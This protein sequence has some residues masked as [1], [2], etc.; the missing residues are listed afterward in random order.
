MQKKPVDENQPLKQ[1]TTAPFCGSLSARAAKIMRYAIQQRFI[2]YETISPDTIQD[3]VKP[4]IF[5]YRVFIRTHQDYL[6]NKAGRRFSIVP[7]MISTVDIKTGEKT[8][9]DYL[10]K[11]FNK[12][13]EAMRER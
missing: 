12:A 7:G 3:E 13:K 10:I 9:L 8:V 4:E 6:T 5:Y 11:P 1:I 2:K